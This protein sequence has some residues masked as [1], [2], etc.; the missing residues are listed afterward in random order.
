MLAP[1]RDYL[2]P[3][4][5]KSSPLLCA[6]KECCFTRLLVKIDPDGPSFGETQWIVSE[7]VN[8]EHLLDIFTT[9][10]PNSDSVWDACTGLMHHIFWHKHRLAILGP[11]IEGL[12]YHHRSKPE[13]LFELS[14]LISFTG[15]YSESKRL[16][17]LTLELWR[18][19][20]DDYEVAR[21]LVYLSSMDRLVSTPEESMRHAKEALEIY[22]RLGGTA[23]Q[24]ECLAALAWPLRDDNQLDAAEEA[25]SRATD[26]LPEK[27]QEFRACEAHLA[28]GNVYRSKGET[29]KAIHHFEAALEVASS[30]GREDRLFW[31]YHP[32][33][34]CASM[35]AGLT[36]HTL[37]SNAQS[38]TR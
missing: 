9:I 25:A 15:Y 31:I 30:S 19:W 21:T 16:L 6:I 12:P 32:W 37:T 23:D 38:H 5:P 20:G 27:G 33:Q 18:E 29:K 10:E 34:G 1:L 24:A 3:E 2:S 11:K 17:T 14:R 13:C 35:K 7:D 22:E 8:V 26:L 4:D 28:L 36:T